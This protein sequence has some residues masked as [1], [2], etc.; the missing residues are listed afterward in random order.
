VARETATLESLRR[1]GSNPSVDRYLAGL[2]AQIAA[3]EEINAKVLLEL[4]IARTGSPTAANQP[5]P[6]EQAMR[7]IVPRSKLVYLHNMWDE[8]IRE[9]ALSI[10]D[11][12]WL[13]SYQERL[14]MAYLRI[15]EFLNF[16]DGR[17]N[18]WEIT[19]SVAVETFDWDASFSPIGAVDQLNTNYRA[20]DSADVRR[21]FTI[22]RNAGLVDW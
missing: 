18:L 14:D 13:K 16:V 15:P 12:Q 5:D 8:L 10:D 4:Y 22:L 19:Q 17:R 7:A 6:I 3:L 11:Q 1:L 2:A 9:K 20:L 21:L